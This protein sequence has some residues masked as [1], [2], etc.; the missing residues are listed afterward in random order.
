[1]TE[2][3]WLAST[4]PEAML[5]HLLGRRQLPWWRVT[6]WLR[7]RPSAAAERPW[8]SDRK[9]RLFACA[10]CRCVSGLLEDR[11][12]RNAVEAAE[13][14][15]DG[16]IDEDM[17]AA[18]RPMAWEAAMAFEPA[19]LP[20]EY[21]VLG[22]SSNSGKGRFWAARAAAETTSPGAAEAAQATQQA[23]DRAAVEWGV[24][25]GN[26]QQAAEMAGAN[27]RASILRDIFGNPFNP[28][29]PLPPA[30]LA[31]SDR[32]VPRIAQGIYDE[33]QLPE[34]TLDAARLAVLADALLDAGC[35]DEDLIAHCRSAGPH[36]RGCWAVDLILEKE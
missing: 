35:D 14:C 31:W 18:V 5:D 2:A 1:M 36:V 16:L 24:E 33:R 17:L 29:P 11:R 8:H 9:L 25:S 30:V 10:C 3:E 34:G 21:G 19:A 20:P 15:A 13:R 32:T 26:L 12:S 7:S 22:G 27:V 23:V 6:D 4:H 28:S